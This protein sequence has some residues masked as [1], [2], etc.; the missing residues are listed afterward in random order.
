M[1][2]MHI[3][4]DGSK[5]G[6]F[7]VQEV[8]A[9]LKAGKFES[10]D[11][12]WIEGT[13][14]WLPLSDNV[15]KKEGVELPSSKAKR[16][17]SSNKSALPPELIGED[18]GEVAARKYA[19]PEANPIVVA[20]VT[21]FFPFFIGHIMNGQPAKCVLSILLSYVLA[22][23]CCCC[24]GFPAIPIWLLSVFEAYKTAERLNDG[25]RIG[26]NEYSVLWFYKICKIFDRK[27]T[28]Q[29]A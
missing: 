27:A 15:F 10:T 24:G 12:A 29:D 28:C 7:T 19:K 8:N 17:Q 3:S 20:L 13:E 26:K 14:G 18:S 9:K 21:F 16:T 22:S 25:E 6:P 4:K 2:K 23:C 11:K 1:S 5:H